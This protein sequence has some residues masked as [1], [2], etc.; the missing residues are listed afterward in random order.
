MNLKALLHIIMI[1]LLAISCDDG[2]ESMDKITMNDGKTI[3]LPSKVRHYDTYKEFISASNFHEL[4]NKDLISY[5]DFNY[6]IDKI[7]QVEGYDSECS[8]NWEK[9]T[10]GDWC[11]DFGLKP[12]EVY[13][14]CTSI[15]QKAMPPLPKDCVITSYKSIGYEMGINPGLTGLGY[16]IDDGVEGQLIFS[17]LTRTIGYDNSHNYVFNNIPLINKKIVWNFLVTSKKD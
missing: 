5:I 3:Y 14:V 11:I 10:F 12:N 2:P 1:S 16:T 17:T 6:R 4:M 7:D 13:Y 9:S 15:Y 8:G